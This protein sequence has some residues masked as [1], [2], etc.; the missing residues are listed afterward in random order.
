MSCGYALGVAVAG[1]PALKTCRGTTIQR[2]RQ[3]ILSLGGRVDSGAEH[4]NILLLKDSDDLPPEL[5]GNHFKSP[6]RHRS[7]L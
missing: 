7:L 4:I 6:S 3:H 5:E 2:T 1:E